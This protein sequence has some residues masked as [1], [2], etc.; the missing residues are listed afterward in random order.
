V[1]RLVL[2]NALIFAILAAA[3]TLAYY[4]YTS[5]Q[6]TRDRERLAMR[7][8]VQEKVASIEGLILGEDDKVF[9]IPF[10]TLVS[11]LP[12]ILDSIHARSIFV[13]DSKRTVVPGGYARRLGTASEKE[14]I[15]F[16]DWFEQQVAPRL[17]L[18][19][20]GYNIRGHDHGI[21]V[22]KE[23]FT[24]R[25][26]LFA[27]IKKQSGD[28]TYYVVIEEDLTYIVYSLFRQYVPT[29]TDNTRSRY[30]FQVIDPVGK[31]VCCSPFIVDA[32]VLS[33][34]AKHWISGLSVLPSAT[35][36]TCASSSASGSSTPCSSAAR[37][38]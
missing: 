6:E 24:Q 10:D 14:G 32:Q 26:Q 36:R 3:V 30:V 23:G 4:S 25:E 17:D 9:A 8:V 22:D 18:D 12:D 34:S 16:R 19:G 15:A 5:G 2:V 37:L 27:F 35:R 38:R 20:K 31:V 11:K 1:R 29:P 7:E 28:R 33:S 21:W 13:L